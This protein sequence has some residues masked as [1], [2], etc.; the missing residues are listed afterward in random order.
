MKRQ[1]STSTFFRIWISISLVFLVIGV[2]AF[3]SSLYFRINAKETT[4]LV[5]DVQN[6]VNSD[7][8]ER[9]VVHVKYSVDGKEYNETI[10]YISGVMV[11]ES[12][13]ILYDPNDPDQVRNKAEIFQISI[14]PAMGILFLG[15]GLFVSKKLKSSGN[16]IKELTEKGIKREAVIEDIVIDENFSYNDR[17]PY[18]I[19][20]RMT[21]D[22][23]KVSLISSTYLQRD[24]QPIIDSH[25][26]TSLPVY[27]DKND[28]TNY[29]IDTDQIS[30]YM[31]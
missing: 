14:F 9:K 10:N 20:C 23:G 2:I 27:V 29:Y 11:G 25:Q 12:A 24:P 30:K 17:H 4:A 28:P 5:T 8:D 18:I 6:T 16:K 3:G 26:I 19:N 1:Q 7:G 15:A 22:E 13:S 31:S 21:D